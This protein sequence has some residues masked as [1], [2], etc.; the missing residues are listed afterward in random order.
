MRLLD[1]GYDGIQIFCGIMDL[2]EVFDRK[3]YNDIIKHIHCA[4]KIVPSIL[5]S[6][7]ANEEKELTVKAKNTDKPGGLIVSRDDSWK[8]RGFSFFQGVFMLISYHFGKVLDF[9][10]KSLYYN[11]YTGKIN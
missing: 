4:A 6:E 10:V 9:I 7:A 8:K 2:S 1:V 3:V 11:R 5:L